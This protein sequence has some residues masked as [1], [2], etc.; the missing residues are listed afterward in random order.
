[1]S[2]K[3][4]I[5]IAT[6]NSAQTI[7][8]CLKSVFD[9]DYN[10]WEIVIVDNCSTDGT[11]AI[12]KDMAHKY[13]V[14]K[15]VT[16][17]IEPDDGI[18]DAFNKG[19]DESSGVFVHH[20][21]SD[22]EYYS[23]ETLRL[24]NDL[25]IRFNPDYICT[26]IHIYKNEK[27][28]RVYKPYF[29]GDK[30]L[31]T[32]YMPPHPGMFIR[33]SILFDVGLYSTHFRISSDYELYLKLMYNDNLLRVNDSN[34]ISVKMQAGGASQKHRMLAFKEDVRVLRKFTISPIFTAVTKRVLKISQFAVLGKS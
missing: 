7:Q 26:T 15:K 31:R 29:Y 23:T 11:I 14:E 27:K 6:F 21:G 16:Y 30:V 25:C 18:Y 13:G 10:C 8:S 28:V 5:I 12:A 22:D 20:L 19:I 1:M 33:K 32:A 34:V 4:S 3:F 9:Q 24:I 17:V 2:L